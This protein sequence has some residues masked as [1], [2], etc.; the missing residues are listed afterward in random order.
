[1]N[2]KRMWVVPLRKQLK[3]SGREKIGQA[4]LLYKS[5][6]NEDPLLQAP[7]QIL[8]PTLQKKGRNRYPLPRRHWVRWHVPTVNSGL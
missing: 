3:E 7:L 1:M 5:R 4:F 6:G 2:R 8:I